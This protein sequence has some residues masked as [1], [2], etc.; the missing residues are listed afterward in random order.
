MEEKGRVTKPRAGSQERLQ[1]ARPHSPGVARNQDP[2][3]CNGH[4]RWGWSRLGAQTHL[5]GKLVDPE[6]WSPQC[7]PHGNFLEMQTL[8]PYPRPTESETRSGVGDEAWQIVL[9]S[10]QMIPKLPKLETL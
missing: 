1:K 4:Q 3:V 9:T 2:H 7:S 5:L 10:S 8:R 6:Q